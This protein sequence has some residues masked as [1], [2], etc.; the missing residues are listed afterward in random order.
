[1]VSSNFAQ[2]AGLL[3]QDTVPGQ[4]VF[5]NLRRVAGQN[6]TEDSD[7]I[8]YLQSGRRKTLCYDDVLICVWLVYAI[9][10]L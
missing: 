7:L 3:A 2:E 4:S 5:V 6:W 1:M 10:S 9:D 8:L